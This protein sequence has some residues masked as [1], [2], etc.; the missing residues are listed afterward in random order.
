MGAFVVFVPGVVWT[1]GTYGS[2]MAWLLAG[3]LPLLLSTAVFAWLASPNTSRWRPNV[4]AS[5]DSRPRT[6]KSELARS[7]LIISLALFAIPFVLALA[8]LSV[9]AALFIGHYLSH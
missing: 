5:R 1:N 8:L 4:P 6:P 9:Y 2:R 3:V 7:V